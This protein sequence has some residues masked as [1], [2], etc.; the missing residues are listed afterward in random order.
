M[1]GKELFLQREVRERG[2]EW[3]RKQ[4]RVSHKMPW[5]GNP[6]SH[7]GREQM[8]PYLECIWKRVHCLSKDKGPTG[9]H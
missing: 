4:H 3:E 5:Y 6:L 7:T 2:R 1:D 9:C 8:F